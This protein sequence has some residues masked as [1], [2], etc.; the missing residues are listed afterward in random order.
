RWNRQVEGWF[1][2][3]LLKISANMADN[4]E[5][6]EFRPDCRINNGGGKQN[7]DLYFDTDFGE[8]VWI[9]L[10]H[11]FLGRYENG[12]N[13]SVTTYC[14]QSTS[15]TPNNFIK[16]LPVGWRAPT[17]LLIVMTPAPK[18]D[19]WRGALR[20]LQN[21]HRDWTIRALTACDEFPHE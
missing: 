18:L 8:S 9:E 7:I 11:W 19:E 2:G 1:K 5:V 3:E 21:Q 12:A 13:W 6:K 16:K 17:Y 4:G 15:G 20:K 10:K 14:T